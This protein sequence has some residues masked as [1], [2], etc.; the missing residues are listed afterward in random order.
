MR[1]HTVISLTAIVVVLAVSVGVGSAATDSYEVINTYF[2]DRGAFTEGLVVEKGVLY[3]ST[4][5]NGA[6]TVRKVDLETGAVLQSVS[7]AWEYFGEGMTIFQGKIFQLTWQSQT[8]FIYDLNT[9]TPIGG[10]Q[11]AGEG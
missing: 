7:L 6:S 11:Y 3:E 4:G 10:F 1:H 5:L 8:G 2:H 9:F